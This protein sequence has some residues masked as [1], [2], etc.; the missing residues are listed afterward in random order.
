MSSNLL[1]DEGRIGFKFFGLILPL[2]P[3][4]MFRLSGT[5]L[6]FKK[7]AK[8]GGKIFHKELINQG[9]DKEKANQLTEMYL[10]NSQLIKYFRSFL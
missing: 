3:G 7:E 8:K 9:M 4:L 10:E 5:F 2:L 1:R 6:R